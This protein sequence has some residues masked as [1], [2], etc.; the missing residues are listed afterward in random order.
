MGSHSH[1]GEAHSHGHSHKGSGIFWHFFAKGR[2]LYTKHWVPFLFDF[3]NWAFDGRLKAGWAAHI[4]RIVRIM[5]NIAI[6]AVLAIVLVPIAI[7]A[8]NVADAAMHAGGDVSHVDAIIKSIGVAI[9]DMPLWAA[10]VINAGMLMNM[11]AVF[12]G[13]AAN[14]HKIQQYYDAQVKLQ[15]LVNSKTDKTEEVGPSR[16]IRYMQASRY[17]HDFNGFLGTVFSAIIFMAYAATVFDGDLGIGAFVLGVLFIG[18]RVSAL[19][20]AGFAPV[21]AQ[22]R[23]DVYKQDIMDRMDMY[24]ALMQN[25]ALLLNMQ[26]IVGTALISLGTWNEPNMFYEKKLIF[27]ACYRACE[28]F[29]LL[30]GSVDNAEILAASRKINILITEKYVK[31]DGRHQV[32]DIDYI[33]HRAAPMQL[34]TLDAIDFIENEVLTVLL[35]KSNE[36]IIDQIQYKDPLRGNKMVSYPV[37]LNDPNTLLLMRELRV[38][39]S[40]SL[41]QKPNNN[42]GKSPLK[43][44]EDK[45]GVTQRLVGLGAL[46]CNPTTLHWQYNPACAKGYVHVQHLHGQAPLMAPAVIA[47]AAQPYASASG[48]SKRH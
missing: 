1:A 44:P 37:A 10:L 30:R 42:S 12:V 21:T 35:G 8:F 31:Y 39:Q 13:S 48:S 25:N 4:S 47:A 17:A 29:L 40:S 15:E 41:D 27:H 45:P 46:Q 24:R 6:L 7:Q 16:A 33:K 36:Q 34:P 14:H 43:N 3:G 22:Y 26:K 28:R 20:S 23:L 5:T 19:I 9:Q 2:A 18:S 32:V 11:F 38:A